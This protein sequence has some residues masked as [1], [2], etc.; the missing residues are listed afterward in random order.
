MEKLKVS[1]ADEYHTTIEN[2]KLIKINYNIPKKLDLFIN[3]S[4]FF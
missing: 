4:N 2:G 1:F 3:L